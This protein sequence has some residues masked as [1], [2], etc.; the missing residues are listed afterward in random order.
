MLGSR[1]LTKGSFMR[2]KA[3]DKSLTDF[4]ATRKYT[5]SS[6]YV[7][8]CNECFRYVK[9]VEVSERPELQKEWEIPTQLD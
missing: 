5:N 3:C 9:G 6:E 8:L 1:K 2:C 7:D 4:E